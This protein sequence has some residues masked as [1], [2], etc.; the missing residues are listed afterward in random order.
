M[1]SNAKIVLRKKSNKDGLYPLAIR[2]TK[3]R[4]SNYH[5]IGHYIALKYWDEKNI[6]I[7]KSH[8]NAERLNNLLIS[9]LSEA[10]KTLLDLQS[11][12][13]DISANQIK[14]EIY[15]SLKNKSFFSVAK[16]YL[17]ELDHNKKLSQLSSDKAR[18][19]CMSS[20]KFELFGSKFKRVL[21]QI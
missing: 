17:D 19:G 6:R 2:I 4:R 5:Y 3:N 15:S 13:K 12:N 20:N 21:S 14:K 18:V 7:R 11:E 8:P 16:A 9:K 10:N 1:A